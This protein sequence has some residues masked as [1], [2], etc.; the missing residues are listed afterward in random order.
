MENQYFDK[1]L[2]SLMEILSSDYAGL[3]RGTKIAPFQFYV[4]AA[5]VAWREGRLDALL[6]VRYV[7][8]LLATTGDRSLRFSLFSSAYT[9]FYP[10]FDVR[11][12]EDALYVTHVWQEGRLQK[13]DKILRVNSLSPLELKK[14][15]QQDFLYGKTPERELWGG[16]LKMAD[17]CLVEHR[18]GKVEDLPLHKYPGK[19]PLPETSLREMGSSLYVGLGNRVPEDISGVLVGKEKVILDLR[20]AQVST[21]EEYLPLVPFI[22]SGKKSMKELVGRQRLKVLYSRGNVARRLALLETLP[23][24]LPDFL[25]ALHEKLSHQKYFG[26]E[27]EEFSLWEDM[28]EEIVPW[29]G[30]TILLIDTWVE[31]ENETFVSWAKKEGRAKIL[32]RPTMGTLDY[33]FPVSVKLSPSTVFTYPMAITEEAAEGRGM[34]GKGIMPDTYLPFTMEECEEDILLHLALGNHEGSVI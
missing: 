23:K 7:N 34:L 12:V 17:H 11:R 33:T 4:Q 25:A 24:P 19:R 9:P 1:Q 29:E 6:F 18:D 8:Q 3:A 16:V 31:G 30:E 5:G 22:L 13:G 28:E 32:G 2:R 15:F 14:S 27:E 21:A 20:G 26:W 10:G